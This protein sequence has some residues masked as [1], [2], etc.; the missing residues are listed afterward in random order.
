MRPAEL[1]GRVEG[2][3]GG[4]GGIVGCSAMVAIAGG[5]ELPAEKEKDGEPFKSGIECGWTDDCIDSVA[6]STG[7]NFNVFDTLSPSREEAHR[8]RDM[9]VVSNKDGSSDVL[10]GSTPCRPF[11]CCSREL[12][13][14]A[15]EGGE[16]FDSIA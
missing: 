4:N 5:I 1:G 7:S 8:L 13:K 16:P 14:V 6:S 2:T 12:S 9:S 11:K 3:E 10:D 15:L